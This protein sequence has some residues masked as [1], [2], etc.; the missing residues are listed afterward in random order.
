MRKKMA[1]RNVFEMQKQRSGEGV[2]MVKWLLKHKVKTNKEIIFQN[3]PNI[4]F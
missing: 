1:Y 3:L 4:S 2:K